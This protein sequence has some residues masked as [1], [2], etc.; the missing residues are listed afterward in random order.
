MLEGRKSDG[1]VD[2][3]VKWIG[4]PS[5]DVSHSACLVAGNR[6]HTLIPSLRLSSLP[7][8]SKYAALVPLLGVNPPCSHGG[9]WDIMS[10]C[11]VRMFAL[12]SGQNVQRW[13]DAA[14]VVPFGVLHAVAEVGL[15]GCMQHRTASTGGEGGFP[16]TGSS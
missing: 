15:G 8:V 6:T 7:P 4:S 14:Q 5:A 1:M 3:W 16:S 2:A 12:W 11:C 9:G 10:A 13:M